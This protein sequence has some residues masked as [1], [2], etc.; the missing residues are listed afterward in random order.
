LRRASDIAN[1]VNTQKR[2]LET[3]WK[4]LADGGVLLYATCSVL[5]DE[6]EHQVNDFLLA[7]ADARLLDTPKQIFPGE[8]AMDGFFY[9][10]VKKCAP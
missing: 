1:L 6:N 4:T 5:K 2:L 7:H 10:A 3:L 8:H 9:A